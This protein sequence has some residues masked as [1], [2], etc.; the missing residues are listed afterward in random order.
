MI[1]DG[2]KKR[3]VLLTLPWDA[4]YT[5]IELGIGN[6]D[7]LGDSEHGMGVAVAGERISDYGIVD[8]VPILTLDPGGFVVVR[9][10]GDR[11]V[12]R[13]PDPFSKLFDEPAPVD[14][15]SMW[16]DSVVLP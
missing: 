4:A 14:L 9:G 7:C 8:G 6:F 15:N 11:M 13:W 10:K 2:Y 5:L 16:D 12:A 1:P 3:G